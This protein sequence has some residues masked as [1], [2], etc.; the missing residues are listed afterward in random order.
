MIHRHASSTTLFTRDV[1]V[2]VVAPGAGSVSRPPRVVAAPPRSSSPRGSR[3]ARRRDACRDAVPRGRRGRAPDVLR[4]RRRGQA[5]PVPARGAG[6]LHPRPRRAS[7][8]L[9]RLLDHEAEAFALFM[10]LVES[11]SFATSDGSMAEGLYGLQRTR[12]A[13]SLRR[14]AVLATATALAIASLAERGG[15]ASGASVAAARAA[16]NERRAGRITKT[17]KIASVACLVLVP[18]LRDKLD[19]LY[20]RWRAAEEEDFDAGRRRRRPPRR[21]VAIRS[22]RLLRRRVAGRRPRRHARRRDSEREPTRNRDRD[23]DR[24][25]D[26]SRLRALLPRVR[27]PP[28]LRRRLPVRAR[29]A[30]RA[31]YHALG[32]LLGGLDCHDPTLRALRVRTARGAPRSSRSAASRRSAGGAYSWLALPTRRV[33]KRSGDGSLHP[34]YARRTSPRTTPREG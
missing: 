29:G 6:V 22:I 30:G 27:P 32:Y 21:P 11:H 14:G 18:Y 15:G 33:R 20:D 25:R 26:H 19:A 4:A 10:L 8:L 13:P 1:R 9:S 12:A 17:Q 3:D 2:P 7:P 16:A 28:R 31:F 5:R 23:R 24:D 34:R